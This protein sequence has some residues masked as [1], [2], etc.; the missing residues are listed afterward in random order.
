MRMGVPAV[1]KRRNEWDAGVGVCIDLW[2]KQL[3]S[4]TWPSQRLS[5]SRVN[6]SNI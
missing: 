6:S 2:I 4:R 5:A 1:M 3:T